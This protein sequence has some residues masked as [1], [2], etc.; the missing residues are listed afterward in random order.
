M[1]IIYRGMVYAKI[2]YG[3]MVLFSEGTASRRIPHR[4]E[5]C[6]YYKF[7]KTTT[8]Y[9]ADVGGIKF[10]LFM[11]IEQGSPTRGPR[12]FSEITN[13]INIIAT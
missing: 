3:G 9:F 4:L 11:N 12:D 6:L 5:H 8:T 2:F 7:H 13:I 10:I 1:V